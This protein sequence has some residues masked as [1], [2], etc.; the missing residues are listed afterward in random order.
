M[1][2]CQIINDIPDNQEYIRER[3]K[4]NGLPLQCLQRRPGSSLSV[5]IVKAIIIPF[6]RPK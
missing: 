1:A 6:K 4:C 5:I 2:V 3:Q